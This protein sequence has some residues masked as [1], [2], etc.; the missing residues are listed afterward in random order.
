MFFL[1]LLGILLH[2]L[3]LLFC[4][5]RLLLNFCLQIIRCL[6]QFLLYFFLLDLGCFLFLCD[7]GFLLFFFHLQGLCRNLQFLLCGFLLLLCFRQFSFLLYL[8]SS[9]V[10]VC[11]L[12]CLCL[13]FIFLCLC[14]CCRDHLGRIRR[15]LLSSSCVC[16]IW[17]PSFKFIEHFFAAFR[18]VVEFLHCLTRCIAL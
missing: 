16:R 2:L 11:R 5:F 8:L 15:N 14:L 10:L 1:L 18:I 6:L 9:L 4:L 13:A 3:L 12:L 7:F 17:L